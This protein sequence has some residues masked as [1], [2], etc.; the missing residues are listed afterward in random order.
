MRQ[1]RSQESNESH[2]TRIISARQRQAISRDLE[3]STQRE[4]RLLS[5]RA[6]TATFRS[7][8]MEEEREV[9]L[10]ADRERHVLSLPSL[11]DLI[12]SVYGNIIEITHQTASWLYE[13][14]ILGLRNDQAVAIN[15]EILR[16]VHGESFKYTSIDTVIEEDDAT[17][18]PLEFLNSISTPGLPAH[19]IALKV[20]NPIILLR[21]LCP[22]K[23]CNE[24]RLKVNDIL[25]QKEIATKCH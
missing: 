22:P 24:T 23:L 25:L 14:T 11:K 6:R 3:S 2:E 19:K 16:H 13:R 8:E 12:S 15:S 1:I 4:A 18:Y 21:N 10:F 17:N 9:R 7:Q 20:G 5:Q